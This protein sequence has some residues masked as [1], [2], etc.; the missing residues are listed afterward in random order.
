MGV[1]RIYSEPLYAL[2]VEGGTDGSGLSRCEVLAEDRPPKNKGDPQRIKVVFYG[3]EAESAAKMLS[4]GSQFSFRGVLA[5]DAEGQL[6]AI[7][8]TIAVS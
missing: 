7:G 8:K 3:K 5:S 2:S 1:I 4:D 6:V